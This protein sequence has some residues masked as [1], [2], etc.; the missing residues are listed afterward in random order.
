M[1]WKKP[2]TH[3]QLWKKMIY[4]QMNKAKTQKN[5]LLPEDK[6][7]YMGDPVLGVKFPGLLNQ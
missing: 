4:G 2:Q 6:Y 7:V 5:N 1:L 3:R